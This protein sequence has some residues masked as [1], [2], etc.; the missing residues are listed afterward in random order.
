MTIAFLICEI[1]VSVTFLVTDEWNNPLKMVIAP[2]CP[3]SSMGENRPSFVVSALF[4]PINFSPFDS[5][6]WVSLNLPL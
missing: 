2:T 1:V 5:G 6:S 4:L 3:S